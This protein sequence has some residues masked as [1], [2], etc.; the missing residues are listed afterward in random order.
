[1]LYAYRQAV[2]K[3]FGMPTGP[4]GEKRPADVIGAVVMIGKIAT[5]NSR[6]RMGGG[7]R[8]L[9]VNAGRQSL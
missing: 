9:G 4:K 6:Q 2:A 3:G 7:S 5:T 1:L 8:G